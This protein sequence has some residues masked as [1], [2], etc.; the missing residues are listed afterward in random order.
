M[1]GMV[2]TGRGLFLRNDHFHTRKWSFYWVAS[3]KK[4]P[5]AHEIDSYIKYDLDNGC[6]FFPG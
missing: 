6:C 4:L 1:V 3:I 2:G 5:Y